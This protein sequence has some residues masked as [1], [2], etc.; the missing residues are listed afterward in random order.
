MNALAGPLKRL[1]MEPP[2]RLFLRTLL[3]G[4]SVSA[5]REP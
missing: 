4:L 1:A 5:S 2:F 3:K